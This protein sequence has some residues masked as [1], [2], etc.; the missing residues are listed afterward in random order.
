VIN[1]LLVRWSNGWH[2][3]AVAPGA[4]GR[5]EA[6]LGLGAVQSISE[7]ERVAGQQLGIYAQTRVAIAA[8]FTPRDATEL[9]YLSYGVGDVITVPA[10][11]GGTAQERLIS[12]TVNEDDDGMV[13]FAPEMK[14]VLLSRAEKFDQAIKKMSDGTL[15]GTSKVAQPASTITTS[16]GKDCCPPPAASGCG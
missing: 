7:L 1:A 6:M 2:E 14:D 4:G 15:G 12:L 8:D 3:I 5:C 10:M 13:T 11:A 9:P 16:A